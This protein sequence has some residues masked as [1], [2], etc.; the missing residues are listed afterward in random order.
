MK[1]LLFNLLVGFLAFSLS[2][3]LNGQTR[4][5]SDFSKLKTS[6]SVKVTLIKASSPSLEYK[7]TKGDADDLITEVDGQTLK[8][9][10]KSNWM[11]SK[12]SRAEV[13]VYYTNLKSIDTSAGSSVEAK[14][15]IN[16]SRMSLDAS[17]GSSLAILVEAD[18][19]DADVSS[20]ASISVRGKTKSQDVDASSGASYRAA[21]LECDNTQADASSGSSVKVVAYKVLEADASSGATVRYKGNPDKVRVDGG[22]SGSVKKM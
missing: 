16:A 11:G 19:I 20:G 12:K 17:S 21:N 14:E 10:I 13:I 1:Q 7:M 4:N 2:T 15:T 9:K 8:V 22:Y 5:I 3:D 18:H 6:G